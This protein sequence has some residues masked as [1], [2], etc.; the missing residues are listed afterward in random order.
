[1]PFAAAMLEGGSARHR[2]R[3]PGTAHGFAMADLPSTTTTP[4][5]AIF[6]RT[7]DSAT[8]RLVQ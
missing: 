5:S 3:V 4:A 2:E 8:A 7:L 1:M 6:E